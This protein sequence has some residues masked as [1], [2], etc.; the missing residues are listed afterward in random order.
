MSARAVPAPSQPFQGGCE[1]LGW[2]QKNQAQAYA[3]HDKA[4]EPQKPP[5][6]HLDASENAEMP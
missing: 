2:H 5:V 4:D 3:N 6:P 1:R